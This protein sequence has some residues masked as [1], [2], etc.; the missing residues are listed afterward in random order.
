LGFQRAD[1]DILYA[2]RVCIHDDARPRGFGSA[3]AVHMQPVATDRSRNCAA[4]DQ[5][6][7]C[8]AFC[9]RMRERTADSAR[10]DDRDLH[11][12]R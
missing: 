1:H 10:S 6:R 11:L 2:D 9:K 7:V 5:K 3:H 4:R 8:T 12:G